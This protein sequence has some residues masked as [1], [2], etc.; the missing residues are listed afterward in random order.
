MKKAEVICNFIDGAEKGKAS[1][2]YIEAGKKGNMLIN[3]A[4]CIAFRDNTGKIILNDYNYSMTTRCNQNIVKRN[5]P[6]ENLIIVANSREFDQFIKENYN[7]NYS[8]F[9]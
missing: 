2:I 8:E 1:N 3:Y 4:S 6:A 9:Y 7:M 5:T